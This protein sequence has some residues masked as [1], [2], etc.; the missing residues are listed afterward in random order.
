MML[1]ANAWCFELLLG[2][3]DVFGAS[4]FVLVEVDGKTV[5]V[6]TVD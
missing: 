4:L 2:I 6:L 5:D 1:L 3:S